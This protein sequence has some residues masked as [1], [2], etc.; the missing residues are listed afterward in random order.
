MQVAGTTMA[1][2]DEDEIKGTLRGSP[3]DDA[4]RY[5]LENLEL[6]ADPAVAVAPNWLNRIPW[7]PFRISLHVLTG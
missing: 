3:L 4:R 2:I 7:F 5:L 6:N 1:E